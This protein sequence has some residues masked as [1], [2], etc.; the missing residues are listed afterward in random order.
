MSKRSKILVLLMLVAMLCMLSVGCDLAVS[1]TEISV[2]GEYQTAY[3]IGDDL[4][5]TGMNLLVTYSSGVETTV[6]VADVMQDVIF[7][8]FN[9]TNAS[10]DLAVTIKYKG[11]SATFNV[12]VASQDYSNQYC[13]VA[14]ETNGG[15]T[16]DPI[17]VN[18]YSKIDI[19]TEPTK[20]DYGFVS[21]YED[22]TLSN[23]WNF[24]VDT[25]Q[26]DMTLYAKWLPLVTITFYT[27]PEGSANN[28]VYETRTVT[29]GGTLSSRPTVPSVEG[30]TGSWDRNSWSDLTT[31][32]SVYPTYTVNTYTITFYDNGT[33]ENL[34][35]LQ[36]TNV[37][38][39]TYL[40]DPAG[41]YYAGIMA[42]ESSLTANSN[43]E[44]YYFDGWVMNGATVDLKEK[45]TGNITAYTNYARNSFNVTYLWNT[46]LIDDVTYET[47]EGVYYGSHLTE[48]TEPP[49]DGYVFMGWY[50]NAD[51]TT[52]WDF[53]N[54]TLTGTQTLYAMWAEAFT[55]IFYQVKTEDYHNETD[56]TC[57]KYLTYTVTSGDSLSTPTVPS[58]TG[59][60]GKWDIVSLDNITSNLEIY[61][62][63]TINTYTVKFAVEGEVISEQTIA[64]MSDA[65]A[66]QDSEV[67]VGYGYEF[68]SW[69][70]TY[71]GITENTTIN[72]KIKEI[73]YTITYISN[74]DTSYG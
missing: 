43:K 54:D 49:L 1:V 11:V 74:A 26:D 8:D 14:F 45:V 61:P 59:Y 42:I 40:L 27:N 63:Y 5:I 46:D 9:T 7:Y 22:S 69:E 3:F 35:M 44:N 62:I 6:S 10:D 18:L 33:G 57:K 28:S 52:A 23:E 32:I 72:A 55:V 38:Y 66:P 34:S 17:D 24:T 53:T 48:P 41:D 16:I 25:V 73:E 29:E 58:V 39:G 50:T 4:S 51:T 67:V 70:G 71:T 30:S 2:V 64:Y 56:I 12:S 31:D 15:S 65:V 37:Y 20:D 68:D 47:Q 19:P 21:W 36:F 60:T 13:T